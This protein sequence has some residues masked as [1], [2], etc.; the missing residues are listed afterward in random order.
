LRGSLAVAA[1]EVGEAPGATMADLS[2]WLPGAVATG[3]CCIAI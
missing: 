2:I 3:I 1:E